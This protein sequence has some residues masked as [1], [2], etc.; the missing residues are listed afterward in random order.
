MQML[1]TFSFS[2]PLC[3]FGLIPT[4]TGCRKV[5]EPRKTGLRGSRLGDLAGSKLEVEPADSD[6]FHG[7]ILASGSRSSVPAPHPINLGGADDCEKADQI[8]PD[9]VEDED[10]DQGEDAQADQLVGAFVLHGQPF[11]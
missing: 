10:D 7:V 6:G 3:F 9:F 11:C 5:K 1:G 8:R 2:F 4:A